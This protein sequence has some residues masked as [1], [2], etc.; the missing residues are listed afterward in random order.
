MLFEGFE[1]DK[2]DSVGVGLTELL[3]NE[4]GVQQP[5]INAASLLK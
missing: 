2:F 1:P 5:E 4:F 3:A